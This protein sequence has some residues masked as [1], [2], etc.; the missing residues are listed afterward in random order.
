MG[1]AGRYNL[2]PGRASVPK[3]PGPGGGTPKTSGLRWTA[4]SSLYSCAKFKD[5]PIC[6]GRGGP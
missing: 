2:K 6:L 4:S 5:G 3:V 1:Q